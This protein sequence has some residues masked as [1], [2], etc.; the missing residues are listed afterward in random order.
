M[1]KTN[2]TESIEST[3]PVFIKA[4]DVPWELTVEEICEAT[5]RKI[6]SGNIAGAV[7]KGGVWR[8]HARTPDD[9]TQLLA[10]P[11]M[12]I[13]RK[14][15]GIGGSDTNG[16]EEV[17]VNLYSK[18]PLN[19]VIIDGKV[20]P[21]VKLIID[22]L[23]LSVSMD[24]VKSSLEKLDGVTLQS[25]IFFDK[26]RRAD[27]TI[28]PWVNGKRYVFI[29]EPSHSKPV[30]RTMWVGAFRAT[31]WHQ[32]MKKEP[33]SCWDCKGPHRRG[34]PA[35][36]HIKKGA[37]SVNHDSIRKQG[38]EAAQK[39]LDELRS[40]RDV[41]FEDKS[42]SEESTSELPGPQQS[43]SDES[44]TP[45]SPVIPEVDMVNTSQVS[46]NGEESPS[47]LTEPQKSDG[48]ESGSLNSSDELTENGSPES[49]VSDNSEDSSSDRTETQQNVD[50][51]DESSMCM[52]NEEQVNEAIQDLVPEDGTSIEE[53]EVTSSG[54]EDVPE[55]EGNVDNIS[56]LFGANEL[57]GTPRGTPDIE[58]V[59]ADRPNNEDTV[60]VLV[61]NES[62]GQFIPGSSS[63]PS[64]RSNH[65][66][67]LTSTSKSQ[68][69]KANGKK[70]RITNL[71]SNYILAAPRRKFTSAF[72]SD[73]HD[74]EDREQKRCDIRKTPPADG[75]MA[76]PK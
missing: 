53:T 45:S 5:E 32:G 42:G 74:G 7:R 10:I 61:E 67:S 20:V 12:T 27:K 41:R 54:H 52:S 63:T 2:K 66:D 47:G 19:N 55:E 51:H 34:D 30:P 4:R 72:G 3:T 43:V 44:E 69:P 29:N 40:Q 33:V 57:Y 59:T 68:T 50:D 9:K 36:P 65:P 16:K 71:I 39:L 60:G 22:G 46:D 56:E 11:S 18:N 25:N 37:W 14:T 1:K 76:S 58:S 8:L 35:C 24:D 31:L 70:N 6:G 64:S 48:D 38:E 26:A 13:V 75:A 15:T 23:Y 73:D 28:S 62:N 21:S 17:L 49:H